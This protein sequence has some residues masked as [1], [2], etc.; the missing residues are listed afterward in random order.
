[1]STFMAYYARNIHSKKNIVKVHSSFFGTNRAKLAL[2][3]SN[4]KEVA[5]LLT[6]LQH[7]VHDQNPARQK[8]CDPVLLHDPTGG[9]VPQGRVKE[10]LVSGFITPVIHVINQ[11]PLAKATVS[12]QKKAATTSES[13]TQETALPIKKRVMRMEDTCPPRSVSY[14]L[15]KRDVCT[16]MAT[17]KSLPQVLKKQ[18][19]PVEVVSV[20]D[21]NIKKVTNS[22]C[23]YKNFH[24]NSETEAYSVTEETTDY[25]K[26]LTKN[27]AISVVSE[28]EIIPPPCDFANDF[29]QEEKPVPSLPLVFQ[30]EQGNV[31]TDLFVVV[32][33]PVL[34]LPS[35]EEHSQ[36]L[37]SE[38]LLPPPPQFDAALPAHEEDNLVQEF[39][40]TVLLSPPPVSTDRS[41]LLFSYW[42]K[43][44][45]FLS[46]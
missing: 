40:N 9:L 31:I 33:S 2:L 29:I 39:Q 17:L 46:I 42:T 37:G 5:T 13:V 6:E 27:T 41:D 36:G 15:G 8:C 35:V 25:Q 7:T 23:V 20:H 45:K 1:M 16:S 38:S 4:V 19:V 34:D 10:P 12:T 11:D 24:E 32:P 30:D 22:K 44:R 18:V 28:G 14:E 26:C 3:S 43:I 21:T